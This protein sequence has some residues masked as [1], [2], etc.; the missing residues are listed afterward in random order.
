VATKAERD[1]LGIFDDV[2]QVEARPVGIGAA[3][4]LVALVLLSVLFALT[5]VMVS[6]HVVAPLIGLFA[7][8][9]PSR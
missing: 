2:R 6:M 5:V 1:G 9:G 3:A 7:V 4:S 8:L